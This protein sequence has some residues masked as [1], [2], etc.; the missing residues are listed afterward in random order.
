MLTF[1]FSKDLLKDFLPIEQNNLGRSPP[2]ELYV[3]QRSRPYL[4]VAMNLLTILCYF[5][6]KQISRLKTEVDKLDRVATSITHPPGGNFTPMP[7]TVLALNAEACTNNRTFKTGE[8]EK[9][10]R[11]LQ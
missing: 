8:P 10:S 7:N 2:L 11:K 6:E 3:G 5:Q 4:L 9:L 1:F